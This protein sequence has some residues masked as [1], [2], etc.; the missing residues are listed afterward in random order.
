MFAAILIILSMSFLDI[1]KARGFQFRPL[2]KLYF[3]YFIAIFLGL[4]ILGAKHVES[5]YIEYG[6]FFT[7]SYFFYFL[8]LVPSAA[9]IENIS[10]INYRN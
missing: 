3:Y 9:Y 6:Q 4:M 1:N 5:P 8:C 7:L 2:S 10:I